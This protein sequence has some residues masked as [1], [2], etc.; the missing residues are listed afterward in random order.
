MWTSM[1]SPVGELR[2]IANRTAITAI[3][4]AG[5]APAGSSGRSNSLS[6]PSK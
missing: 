6:S 1:D 3:E 4:F 2:I 5:P